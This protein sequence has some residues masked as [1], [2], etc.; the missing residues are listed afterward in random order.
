MASGNCLL[1]PSQEVVRILFVT[2]HIK[3]WHLSE[4]TLLSYRY[5]SKCDTPPATCKSDIIAY[6]CVFAME[7]ESDFSNLG[8]I[9]EFTNCCF[10]REG[11]TDIFMKKKTLFFFYII[12]KELTLLVLLKYAKGFVPFENICFALEL[13][14]LF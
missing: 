11:P 9:Q 12:V 3:K 8:V 10:R 5:G 4:C 7:L 13:L 1:V 2:H 6:C 14:D